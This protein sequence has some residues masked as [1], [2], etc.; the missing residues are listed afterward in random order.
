MIYAEEKAAFRNG[1]KK[2]S[3]LIYFGEKLPCFGFET[4]LDFGLKYIG[5]M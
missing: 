4:R 1:G 5:Y 3:I 2:Y